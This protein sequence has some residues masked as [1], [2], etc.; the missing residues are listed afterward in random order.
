MLATR[1][2]S[3]CDCLDTF[4]PNPLGGAL[5]VHG[6]RK[7]VLERAPARPRRAKSSSCAMW[8]QHV[9]ELRCCG[10][11]S[12]V[13]MPKAVGCGFSLVLTCT[14]ADPDSVTMTHSH[15]IQQP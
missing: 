13:P 10:R 6:P 9:A 7:A 5:L 15:H 3:S 8:Q 2:C 11:A 14:V 1:V 12:R 4:V